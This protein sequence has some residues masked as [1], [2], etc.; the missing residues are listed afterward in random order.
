MNSNQCVFD[1]IYQSG[2]DLTYIKLYLITIGFSSCLLA[3][4][5]ASGGLFLATLEASSSCH[6]SSASSASHSS[7]SSHWSPLEV[8]SIEFARRWTSHWMGWT[9]WASTLSAR[10]TFSH[11][12]VWSVSSVHHAVGSTHWLVSHHWPVRLKVAWVAPLV[13]ARRMVLVVWFASS[14]LIRVHAHSFSIIL[15]IWTRTVAT[16]AGSHAV[17]ERLMTVGRHWVVAWSMRMH[18]VLAA[19][20]TSLVVVRSALVRTPLLFLR[21]SNMEVIV[22]SE[23]VRR[24]K[25]SI[26]L[27]MEVSVHWHHASVTR[28]TTEVIPFFRM[29]IVIPLAGIWASSAKSDSDLEVSLLLSAFHVSA[30]V[31]IFIVFDRVSF[32][33]FLTRLAFLVLGWTTSEALRVILLAFS[34][35][36]LVLVL[37]TSL[38]IFILFVL[39]GFWVVPTLFL[40][41]MIA[42]FI[43][44]FAFH[45]FFVRWESIVAL[46]F[47]AFL[48]TTPAFGFAFL[49]LLFRL[50]FLDGR[51]ARLLL[52]RQWF[53]VSWILLVQGI[54]RKSC[55]HSSDTPSRL[56]LF[57][58]LDLAVFMADNFHRVDFV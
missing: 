29:G 42:I 35:L 57:H 26:S 49:L 22:A 6:S 27:M 48:M 40:L 16:V 19:S 33:L 53:L 28:S 45:L 46:C 34:S 3:S 13:S 56:D 18:E 50:L 51:R 58:A 37:W 44:L 54:L 14:S 43:V 10:S 5:S 11:W 2:A 1:I 36:L 25:F 55:I 15:S 7:S 9:H 21:V 4:S 38:I 32:E 23:L 41:F 17:V 52:L 24:H 8:W 30:L 20:V 31:P 12:S 47:W 39:V